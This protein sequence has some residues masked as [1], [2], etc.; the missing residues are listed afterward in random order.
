MSRLLADHKID[1]LCIQETHTKDDQDM[2]NRGQIPG[3]QLIKALN[4]RSYGIATYI[5]AGLKANV[6]YFDD[7]A[8]NYI[9]VI[10]IDDIKIA[11]IYKP[12]SASWANNG[13]P[14]FA[15]PC[16]YTGDFN[17]HHT[18]WR[19]S[20]DD[21]N[22]LVLTQWAETFNL[23]LVFD[24]KER[25][26]FRSARWRKDYNPDL[27]FVTKDATGRA[28]QASRAVLRDF[29]NSQ[30]RPVFVE[31]GLKI[32]LVNSMPL[33][34]W[35]FGRAD[36]NAFAGHIEAGI[37]FIPP[38][39][40]NYNRFVGLLLSS[41]KRH[42][43]RGFRKQYIPGWNRESESLFKTY[44]ETGDCSIGTEL[45]QSLDANRTSKWKQTVNSMDFKRSSRKAWTV[46]NKLTGKRTT[47]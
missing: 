15:H 13:P 43:C 12:P 1:V 32:P 31:V 20:T 30:H 10:Q 47:P 11:N 4:H 42:V 2:E 26:T 46:L 33:P 39:A 17:S 35:N 6:V 22:G 37:R 41:A 44:R 24:A 25:G 28:L 23:F 19:Y 34:R 7:S 29:P 3:Y 5:R 38:T 8:D 45:L 27:V 21:V 14:H 9:I 18:S 40:G 16:V 36:W